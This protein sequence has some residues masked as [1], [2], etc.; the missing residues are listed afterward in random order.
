MRGIVLYFATFL[1]FLNHEVDFVCSFVP[2]T[3]GIGSILFPVRNSGIIGISD[4]INKRIEIQEVSE[5]FVDS[6]WTSKVGGGARTLDKFQRQQ[7]EQSQ[8]AEFTK[9]YGNSRKISEML[10]VRSSSNDNEI[11]ACVGVEVDKIPTSGTIRSPITTISAP[12]MSNLAVSRKYRRRGLAEQMVRSVE[13]VVR[14][15]WGYD[16]CYLYVEERNRPA[17]QLYQ[18]LGYRNVWRDTTASTLLPTQS[19]DL[20]ITPTVI[21][22]MR[23]KLGENLFQRLFQR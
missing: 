10:L 8:R 1:L 6:F 5:F 9:R 14:K 17:V 2:P 15:Q 4:N 3:L 7:L 20:Q 16:E 11:M 23:K 22:C 21:I 12:L 13:D 19:G 18:K